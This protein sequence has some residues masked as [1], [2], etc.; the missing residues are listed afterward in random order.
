MLAS[1]C[2]FGWRIANPP[3]VANLPHMGNGKARLSFCSQR[4]LISEFT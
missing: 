3:Q 2:A 4:L 1:F